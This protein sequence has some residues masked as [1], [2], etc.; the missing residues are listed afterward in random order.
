MPPNSVNSFQGNFRPP[1]V[2]TGSDADDEE[3]QLFFVTTYTDFDCL[4]MFEHE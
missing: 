3:E 4:G 1:S 2:M